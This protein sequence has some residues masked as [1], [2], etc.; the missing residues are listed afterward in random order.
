MLERLIHF[1]EQQVE[2]SNEEKMLGIVKRWVELAR[3]QNQRGQKAEVEE[4]LKSAV[5]DLSLLIQNDQ[6]RH[7]GK[8]ILINWILSILKKIQAI[9]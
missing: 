4:Y 7:L 5:D 8:V 6:E 2:P 9:F 3:T 1:I